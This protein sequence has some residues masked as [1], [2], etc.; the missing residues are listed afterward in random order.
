MVGNRKVLRGAAK[1]SYEAKRARLAEAR[2]CLLLRQ[3]GKQAAAR[4][5]L[6]AGITA[7]ATAGTA[8]AAGPTAVGIPASQR[9]LY[10]CSLQEIQL[11]NILESHTGNLARHLSSS[12]FC[13]GFS[14]ES[15]PLVAPP[16]LPT[17]NLRTRHPKTI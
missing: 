10:L 11:G 16:T 1:A 8:G 7:P 17:K 4:V 6:G 12:F 14:I 13:S 3:T 9:S 5:I 15:W 2:P